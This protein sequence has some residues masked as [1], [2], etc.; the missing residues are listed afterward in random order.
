MQEFHILIPCKGLA[1]G[2]SRL[3]PVLS[4]AERYDLCASLLSRT[5]DVVMQIARPE[6]VWL[7]TAD[8]RGAAIARDYGVA[9]I[10]EYGTDLNSTL[11]LARKHIH[12]QTGARVRG[13]MVLPIDLPLADTTAIKQT[14]TE[15]A[16]VSVAGD[17]AKTGTNL[18]YLTGAAA[19]DFSFSFGPNSF[20]RHCELAHRSRYTL[21]V[22]DDSAL[23]FD[24]DDPSDLSQLPRSFLEICGR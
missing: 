11:D 2:K 21:S 3:A 6:R 14:L 9:V 23:A 24:L 13:L 7:T 12:E 20:T 18:L 4:A 17:R 16:D 5:M 10:P 1:D 15:S 8:R 19:A 22:I